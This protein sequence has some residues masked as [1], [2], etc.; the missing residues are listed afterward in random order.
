MVDLILGPQQTTILLVKDRQLLPNRLGVL[1]DKI[2][3]LKLR[4]RYSSAN[5]QTTTA[6]REKAST[7][8]DLLHNLRH[9]LDLTSAVS[10]NN[11]YIRST[12]LC[13]FQTKILLS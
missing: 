12:L 5:Q 10:V 11:Y 6:Q 8:V 3:P 2:R 1:L 7:L 9:K 13:L 4:H